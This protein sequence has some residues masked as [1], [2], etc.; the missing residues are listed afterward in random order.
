MSTPSA[1]PIFDGHNDTL[2]R[3]HEYPAGDTQAFF[4]DGTPICPTVIVSV[5]RAIDA[6]TVVHHWQAGDLLIVDNRLAAHGR[7]PFRGLRRIA[8][9]MT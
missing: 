6:E 7:M 5:R 2:L 3:L 8:V 9:A 4:G 1:L